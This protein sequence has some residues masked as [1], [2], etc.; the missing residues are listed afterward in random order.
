MR[1][2]RKWGPYASL[3]PLYKQGLAGSLRLVIM[4]EAAHLT[5]LFFYFHTC[6]SQNGNQNQNNQN[7]QNKQL[8]WTSSQQGNTQN[9][10]GQQQKTTQTPAQKPV[11]KPAVVSTLTSS[12]NSTNRKAAKVTGWLAIGVVAGVLIAWGATSLMRH[13]GNSATTAGFLQNATSTGTTAT[14]TLLMV[15]SPQKA[16]TTVEVSGVNVA[17]PTWVVVN[18]SRDGKPSNVL[19]AALFFPGNASGSVTL[20]RTTVAGQTY[21]VSERKDNGD[22]RFSMSA[23]VP[24]TIDGQPSTATFTAN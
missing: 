14:S 17:E 21:F 6:M 1:F 12:A 11:E 9:N 4:A 16:G 5:Y 15:A 24:V 13:N 22:H 2:C 7:N 8:S 3:V 19:G 18:E 20:L 23:D 10:A